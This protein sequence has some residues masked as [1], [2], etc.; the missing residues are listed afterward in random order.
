[1]SK[2]ITLYC[3]GTSGS[4]DYDILSK[5]ID[6]LGIEKP[7]PVD[8]IRG[9]GA[10]INYLE[11]KGATQSDFKILFRDRDF[12]KA[13]PE[14]PI[15]EQDTE[16][17]YC[18]F[19][20]RNTIENYLFEDMEVFFQFI[21]QN[22]YQTRYHIQNLSDAKNKLIEAAQRIKIYQAIRHT[23]G[24]MRTDETNFG[25]KWTA[26]SGVLP[27][28][29]E[30]SYCKERALEKIVNAKNLTENWTRAGFEEIYTSF[31]AR[32]NEEFMNNRQFLI[33]FQGKD[34]ASSLQ[35]VMPNFSLKNYY[36]FA[37]EH[38]KYK[39]FPDL[40]ELRRLLENQL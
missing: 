4:H 37:K 20:Y 29:L 15:L 28:S 40:V 13:I 39:N 9:A 2:I 24:K 27:D 38:F 7:V 25:T 26:K 11:T 12:D 1:M 33:Y 17:K 19:S 8:S 32:F 31:L 34:L 30:E 21:Q 5:V 23:M 10:I 16:R 36:K 14:N 22:N 18:Y 6:G 35:V 3:E